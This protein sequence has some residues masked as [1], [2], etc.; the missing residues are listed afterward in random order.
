MLLEEIFKVYYRLWIRYESFV[1]IVVLYKKLIMR[2]K[3]KK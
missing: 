3:L 2:R 1:S